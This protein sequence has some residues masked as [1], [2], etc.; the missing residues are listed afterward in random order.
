MFQQL[1]SRRMLT[2]STHEVAEQE[3]TRRTYQAGGSVSQFSTW[4]LSR[5]WAILSSPGFQVKYNM[6]F[7]SS[8][9]LEPCKIWGFRAVT[10]KNGVFW[11]VTLCGSCKTDVSE[12]P[13]TSFN[14][15]TR[16]GELGTTLALT[17]NCPTLR[18]NDISS[19]RASVASYT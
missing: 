1:T 19:Q 4:L 10:K 12:E 13:S 14:T 17:S 15:V 16:I 2:T 5:G 9:Y 8:R 3:E 18:R 7:M 6:N 11:D